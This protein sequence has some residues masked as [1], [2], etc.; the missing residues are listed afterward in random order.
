MPKEFHVKGNK[1]VRLK[2]EKLYID[3]SYVMIYLQL[4]NFKLK[5]Q[6]NASVITE[7]S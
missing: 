3:N 7:H 6:K 1:I 4:S 5:R 2:K